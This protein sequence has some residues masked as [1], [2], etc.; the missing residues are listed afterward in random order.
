MNLPWLVCHLRCQLAK[1]LYLFSLFTRQNCRQA[2]WD[3]RRPEDNTESFWASG[4]SLFIMRWFVFIVVC[5]HF[6]V[7]VCSLLINRQSHCLSLLCTFRRLFAEFFRAKHTNWLNVCWFL[8]AERNVFFWEALKRL[9]TMDE[10][11][12][13]S[14][15]KNR[16]AST[17]QQPTAAQIPF[18]ARFA[19]CAP[20][21]NFVYTVRR[22]NPIKQ[23]NFRVLLWERYST[24]PTHGIKM[25]RTETSC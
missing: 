8:F 11:V 19:P 22:K 25:L 20:A 14:I 15:H 4:F 3:T 17:Q 13:V 1:K 12:V 9:S 5:L 2:T 16:R 6:I 7:P 18:C 21:S 23:A 24:Q 10:T